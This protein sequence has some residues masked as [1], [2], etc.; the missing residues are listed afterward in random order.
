[1]CGVPLSAELAP[2]LDHLAGR[3][4]RGDLIVLVGAGVSRW[5]GLPTWREV[6]CTLARDLA[7]ALRTAVPRRAAPLPAARRM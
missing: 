2:T 1:M 4:A 3:I 5:A 6:A 7:P